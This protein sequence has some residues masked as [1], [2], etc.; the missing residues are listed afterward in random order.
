MNY[1]EPIK[2]YKI[3][4][5]TDDIGNQIPAEILLLACRANVNGIGGKEYYAAAQQKADKDI[6]FEVRYCSALS[7]LQPQTTFIEFRSKRYDVKNI[8]NYMFRNETLKIK[9]V[10]RN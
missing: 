4:F 1:K 2:I 6:N 10:H 5:T 9:A 7:D 3:N 8:D